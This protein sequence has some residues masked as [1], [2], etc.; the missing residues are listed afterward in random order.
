MN[1]LKKSHQLGQMGVTCKGKNVDSIISNRVVI[2]GGDLST[3]PSPLFNIKP[4]FITFLI[5]Y[6]ILFLLFE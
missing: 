2:G 1:I 6:I 5:F 4:Y 3:A